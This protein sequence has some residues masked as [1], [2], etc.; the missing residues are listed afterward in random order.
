[1]TCLL[2]EALDALQRIAPLELAAN[3]DNVGLL[4][5]PK[6]KEGARL[7]SLL[8]TID[9]TEPVLAEALAHHVELIVAYHPPIFS[10]LKRLTRATVSERVALDS[11]GAGVFVYSPH[12]ALDA[13]EGGLND[14]LA[15]AIG[16]GIA[17][18]I[19]PTPGAERTGQGRLLRLDAPTRLDQAIANIKAHLELELLRVARPHTSENPV[20]SCVA[21]CAGAGGSVL[22][23]VRADLFLTGEMRHHDILSKQ[24]QGSSVVLCDHTN[25]ERGYLPLLAERLDAALGGRATIIV[26]H[27]DSDP[28]RV[29]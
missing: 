8:L 22:Q 4:V 7:T 25:T 21:V 11:I 9:L 29:T 19:E 26:S 13:S 24:A 5:E 12:T 15:S 1:M 6:P 18:P 2:T 23:N 10:G 17:L 16:P 14:W 28:L 3:W 20:L 27:A